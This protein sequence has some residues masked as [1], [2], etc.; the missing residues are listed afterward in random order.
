MS[1]RRETAVR[2][3]RAIS[4]STGNNQQQEQH[5]KIQR[6]KPLASAVAGV[7][8]QL[9]QRRMLS[10]AQTWVNDTWHFHFDDDGSNSLTLG[11]LVANEDFSIVR[12]YGLTAFGDVTSGSFTGSL[13]GAETINDAISNTNA[14]GTVTL[15]QGSYAENVVVNRAV[16]LDGERVAAN[17]AVTLTTAINAQPLIDV[18]G[19]VDSVGPVD[20][21]VSINDINFV[22]LNG[23]MRASHGVRVSPS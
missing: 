21:D 2:H 8:E 7:L 6:R 4:S 22:G 19:V 20:A 15:Q 12:R 23:A 3:G 18:V 17:L 9:E 5:Q 14:S 16:T 1:N 10:S 13:A 11:D